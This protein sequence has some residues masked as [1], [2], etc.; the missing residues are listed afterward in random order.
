MYVCAY[1]KAM[2][3]QTEKHNVF[4]HHKHVLQRE[5]EMREVN[6]IKGKSE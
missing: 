6:E 5:S 2:E 4:H 3:R 1:E